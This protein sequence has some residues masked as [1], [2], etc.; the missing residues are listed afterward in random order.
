MSLICVYASMLNTKLKKKLFPLNFKKRHIL[1]YLTFP[2]YFCKVVFFS[3][4]Q[5]ESCASFPDFV[6]VWEERWEV[7]SKAICVRYE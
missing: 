7:I 1:T 3:S 5:G 6:P 4:L 2:G